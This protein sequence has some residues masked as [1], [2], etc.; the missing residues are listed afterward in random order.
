MREELEFKSI[1]TSDGRY[2]SRE[3]IHGRGRR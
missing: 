1:G 2:L 3:E